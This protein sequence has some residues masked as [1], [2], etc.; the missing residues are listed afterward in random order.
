MKKFI[1]IAFALAALMLIP[2][3]SDDSKIASPIDSPDG[4]ASDATYNTLTFSWNAV[5]NAIQYAYELISPEGNSMA[6]EVT[7]ETS[8][9]FTNLTPSSTYTLKVRA[10]GP[11]YSEFGNSEEQILTGTTA[12]IIKLESPTLVLSEERGVYSV[13]WNKVT[14]AKTYA[15]KVVN[16]DGEEME[17]GSIKTRSL[18]FRGYNTGTY[19]V[20]VM[21]ET[22]TGGYS[23]SDPAEIQFTITRIEAWRATGTYTSAR[24]KKS[25]EATLISYQDGTYVIRDFYGASGYDFEFYIDNSDPDDCFRVPEIYEYD[26]SAYTY[27]VPTGITSPEFVNV[28][29][30]WN[31]SSFRGNSMSGEVV[32]CSCWGNTSGE[33]KFV[34]GPTIANLVGSYSAKLKGQEL[35]Y[36]Y[37]NWYEFNYTTDVEVT[38][39]DDKTLRITPFYYTSE[40]LDIQ[41]DLSTG[42]VTIPLQTYYSWFTIASSRLETAPAKGSL[43]IGDDGT[44]TIKLS[45][46]GAWFDGY[47]YFYE[48][49]VTLTKK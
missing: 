8:V 28:Y 13:T 48:P 34:W 23:N 16:Q 17:S 20:T 32:I 4:E 37:T 46:F 2:A 12:D 30:W 42:V 27:Y 41:P 25:W 6:T 11:V 9:T 35:M 31:Y 36:D 43:T 47:D 15:Y 3:C 49:V 44:V 33:D 40:H 38:Q 19:T 21:A 18:T 29:P 5:E 39:V 22:T 1:N 7:K 10:L 24:L 45:N 26:S 14:N